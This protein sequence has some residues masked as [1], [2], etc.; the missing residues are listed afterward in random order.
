M[1]ARRQA[2]KERFL[3]EVNAPPAPAPVIKPPELIAQKQA[4]GEALSN[5]QRALDVSQ[6]PLPLPQVASDVPLASSTELAA[7]VEALPPPLSAANSKRSK[8]LRKK[9]R[10]IAELEGR[11]VDGAVLSANQKAKVAAK[12]DITAELSSIDASFC[13]EEGVADC[14]NGGG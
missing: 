3:R 2:R 13:P 4:T 11:M 1:A 14:A 5:Q 10:E 7:K 9:L 8:T 12:A 6:D